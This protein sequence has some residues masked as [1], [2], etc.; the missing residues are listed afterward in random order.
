[1]SLGDSVARIAR[2]RPLEGVSGALGVT[3]LQKSPSEH[4]RA[5]RPK[6]LSFT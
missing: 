4:V 6:R 3:E 2:Q 1:L 5:A